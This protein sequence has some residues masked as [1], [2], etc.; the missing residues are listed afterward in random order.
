MRRNEEIIDG[1]CREL[2]ELKGT[3]GLKEQEVGV[4]SVVML[5]FLLG[6]RGYG[7]YWRVRSE[8]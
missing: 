2:K 1:L 5:T 8:K 3:L 7:A 6:S 4:F